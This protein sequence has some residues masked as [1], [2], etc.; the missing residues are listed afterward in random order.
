MC[1]TDGAAA[2]YITVSSESFVD[3]DAM[4]WNNLLRNVDVSSA[5]HLLG[6]SGYLVPSTHHDAGHN[7]NTQESAGLRRTVYSITLCHHLHI[8]LLLGSKLHPLEEMPRFE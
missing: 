7:A 4:A 5:A 3:V 1:L 2:H 6:N 8:D